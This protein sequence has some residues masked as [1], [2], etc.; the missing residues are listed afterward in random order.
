MEYTVTVSIGRNVGDEP[1]ST[2]VW[3]DFA[4]ATESAIDFVK[5]EYYVRNANGAG[6]WQDNPE[7]SKTWVFSMDTTKLSILEWRMSDLCDLFKQ[8]AIA[9]TYG[10]TDLVTSRN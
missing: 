5:T 6:G 10:T 9:V 8:D 3:R 1:M 2:N 7:D 4:R